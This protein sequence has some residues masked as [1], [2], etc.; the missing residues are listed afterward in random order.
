MNGLQSMHF[1]C[2]MSNEKVLNYF[3]GAKYDSWEYYVS[4][5]CWNARFL[6]ILN[7]WNSKHISDMRMNDAILLQQMYCVFYSIRF[8]KF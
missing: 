3:L 1:E 7:K 8:K 4:K 5:N 6:Y 2:W